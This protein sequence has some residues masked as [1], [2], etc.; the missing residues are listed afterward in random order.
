[1]YLAR[2]HIRK[3]R[4]D[5]AD[6]LISQLSSERPR[7]QGVQYL[8]GWR[9]LR[10]GSYEEA[11]SSF[12][13]VLARNDRDVASFRDSA[14]CLY[15]L[16]RPQEA[17]GLLRQAKHIESD[18]SFTLDL[19][20][21][22]YEE[23]GKFDDALAAARTAVVRN[24]LNWALHHRLSRILT[25][26]GRRDEAIKEARGAVALDPA[27]FVALSNLVS[28]LIDNDLVEEAGE[29]QM[30]LKTLAV[31]Q[32]ER[33]ICEHIRARIALRTGAIHEALELVQSQIGHGRNL[34]ASYGLLGRIRL[35]QA[36]QAVDGSATGKLHLAQ[37]EEAISK[38]E[39]QGDH[40]GEAVGSLKSRLMSLRVGA[41]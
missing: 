34:A 31:S 16:R 19:E 40:D 2:I 28:L 27:Q 25:A 6:R 17:L 10:Q 18:N 37:A 1:M 20:A 23:M 30:K 15:K 38:C 26:L 22:I 8:R 32:K 3:G 12:S 9:L 4:W 21:R 7:N 14:Y 33:D 5:E 39:E 41:K 24:H 36:E 13:R 29:N 11:L 35:V